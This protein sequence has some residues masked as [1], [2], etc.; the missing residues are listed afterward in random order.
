MTNRIQLKRTGNVSSIPSD[1]DLEY[2]ELALNYS[3]GTLYYKSNANVVTTLANAYG[4]AVTG[5]ITTNSEVR[6]NVLGN[7]NGTS[8]TIVGDFLPAANEAYSLGS[9]SR[10]WKDMHLAGNTIYIGG[11]PISALAGAVQ[12]QNFQ[13][14]SFQVNTVPIAADAGTGTISVNNQEIVTT[15]SFQQLP[16]VILAEAQ[17]RHQ[18]YKIAAFDNTD[19]AGFGITAITEI[20]DLYVGSVVA[21]AAIYI[22]DFQAIYEFYPDSN[23]TTL[24]TNV[25]AGLTVVTNTDDIQYKWDS[26]LNTW[27][28]MSGLSINGNA[29][30]TNV[31][32]T[33]NASFADTLNAN[34][35][36]GDF[37]V[38]TSDLTAANISTSGNLVVGANANANYFFGNGIFLEGVGATYGEANV[39]ELLSNLGNVINSNANISTN[40]NISA[41]GN[42]SA[43]N[44]VS[45][46]TG[47]F[48]LLSVT[49]NVVSTLIPN[50]N[51][52]SNLGSTDN[53]WGNAWF[54][55]TVAGNL[56]VTGIAESYNYQTGAIIAG[57]GIS[58]GGNLNVN[59][60]AFIGGN[61]T[62]YGNTITLDSNVLVINDRN[63]IIGN[64]YSDS[65]GLDGAGI[66]IGNP[67]L[68]FIRW[69]HDQQD[70][71]TNSAYTIEGNINANSNVNVLANV[72]IEGNIT[73][74]NL[75][76]SQ[77]FDRRTLWMTYTTS[78]VN[79]PTP[80]RAGDPENITTQ[81]SGTIDGTAVNGN[82]FVYYSTRA[83][84]DLEANSE[85]FRLVPNPYNTI[86]DSYWS[87]FA[88]NVVSG[89]LLATRS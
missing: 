38:L 8:I 15:E 23:N 66:N 29:I 86:Y 31:E 17:N 70:L 14:N 32:I 65:Q 61:L 37:V 20:A 7:N 36:R 39:I 25:F 2:G 12:I 74:N 72:Y 24:L 67:T 18:I 76:S 52:I 45:A 89:N 34:I 48:T 77:E 56:T 53:R 78:F 80:G 44:T 43:Y 16:T 26:D 11:I 64:N 33:S 60:N 79:N 84:G 9:D 49:G 62:V 47:N 5:N 58:A 28:T 73:A 50:T 41:N 10:R 1:A 87:E 35:I 71:H 22:N 40:A 6:T 88:A 4:V 85:Y 30:F 51:L 69:R 19:Y 57:G 54:G 55:N 59:G 13:T 27:V 3:D 21:N 81:G 46:E 68:T 42:I 75:V 82:V 63:I 83:I